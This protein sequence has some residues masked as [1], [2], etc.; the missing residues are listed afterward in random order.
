VE[1]AVLGMGLPAVYLASRLAAEGVSVTLFGGPPD[2]VVEPVSMATVEEFSLGD[3]VV[4][5]LRFLAR[6]DEEFHLDEERVRGAVIDV[7]RLHRNYL[8]RAVEYGCEVLAGSDFHLHPELKVTWRGSRVAVNPDLVVLEE[9][10]GKK[11][12]AFLVGRIP[13]N[14]DSVEF[15]ESP[16]MWVVPA[17]K[18]AVVGGELDLSWH[19]FEQAAFIRSYSLSRV[20]PAGQL[21]GEVVRLGRAAGHTSAEGF[22]LE[23]SLYHARLLVDLLLSGGDLKTYEKAARMSPGGGPTSLE[24]WLGTVP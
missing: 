5:K 7:E 6:F 14:E 24:K 1:V 17:G 18:L 19:R 23:P 2:M 10:Q 13:F 22:V 11:V 12:P 21:V 20:L 4:G 16:R 9:E 8:R 3:F 15:Y